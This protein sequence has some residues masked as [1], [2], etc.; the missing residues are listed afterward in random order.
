[1][2]HGIVEGGGVASSNSI[3]RVS[4]GYEGMSDPRAAG[5]GAAGF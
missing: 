5:G 4:G 2:G 3:M 1:M